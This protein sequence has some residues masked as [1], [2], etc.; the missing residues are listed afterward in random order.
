[1]KSL[2]TL[3]KKYH[4]EL[5]DNDPD[6]YFLQFA[7]DQYFLTMQD[8]ETIQ[9]GTNMIVI[10]PQLYD[11][12]DIL[13]KDSESIVEGYFYA[14][15]SLAVT[16]SGEDRWIHVTDKFVTWLTALC[17]KMKRNHTKTKRNKKKHKRSAKIK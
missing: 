16:G 6:H 7:P 11:E 8:V 14:S 2:K 9:S 10:V 15:N 13:T 1:M 17:K 12:I 5:N 3:L 4:K